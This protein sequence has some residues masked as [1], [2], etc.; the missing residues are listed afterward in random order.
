MELLLNRTLVDRGRGGAAFILI[1]T[2]PS[3]APGLELTLSGA[4]LIYCLL[5]PPDGW[6][7]PTMLLYNSDWLFIGVL[8]LLAYNGQ[9]GNSLAFNR[10]FFYI[11]IRYISGF[12]P[13]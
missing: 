6:Q 11:F 12:W 10:Y 3:P 7:S 9:R 8:P 2:A 5:L 4:S 13:W 1:A